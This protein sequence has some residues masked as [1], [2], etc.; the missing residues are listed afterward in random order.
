[1]HF[2]SRFV[3]TVSNP[4]FMLKRNDGFYFTDVFGLMFFSPS[5]YWNYA[6]TI[7]LEEIVYLHCHQQGWSTRSVITLVFVFHLFF[8]ISESS[9]QLY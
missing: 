8:L 4:Y 6:M 3:F 2:L 1:M 7:P 5:I 9:S